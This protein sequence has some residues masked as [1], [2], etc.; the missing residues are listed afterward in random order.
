[1]ELA[2]LIDDLNFFNGNLIENYQWQWGTESNGISQSI[3]L[4]K[5]FVPNK[6]ISYLYY[7]NEFCE[8][9]IPSISDLKSFFTICISND[10]NPVLVTPPVSDLGLEKIK[11]LI[12][13]VIEYNIKISIVIND[14]GAMELINE[15]NSDIKI[16]IGRVLD[17]ISHDSRASISDFQKYYGLNGMKY[18][19]TPGII[20]NYSREVLERYNVERWEFDMPKIGITLPSEINASLYY[21]YTYL[22]TGRVCSIRASQL[23]GRNMYLVGTS[24]CNQK[25]ASIQIQKRKPLYDADSDTQESF[26]FQKGNTLFYLNNGIGIENYDILFDRIILQI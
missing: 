25:C 13:Y 8:Y 14:L 21:P 22:T 4:L 11:H 6:A 16:I 5:E 19:Q 9:R 24:N 20:S 2:L 15:T 12:D 17:K 1:M 7:G 26:L 10:L 23:Q 18:A 3:I